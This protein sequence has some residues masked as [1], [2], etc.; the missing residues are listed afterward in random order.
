[1]EQKSDTWV[2]LKYSLPQ[3]SLIP[4]LFKH[5]TQAPTLFLSHKQMHKGLEICH[6]NVALIGPLPKPSLQLAKASVGIRMVL[7]KFRWC[8]KDENKKEMVGSAREFCLL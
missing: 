4:A 6:K 7:Q 1:M 8:K 2:S 3:C 5:L